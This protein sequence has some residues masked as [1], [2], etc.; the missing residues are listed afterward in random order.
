MEIRPLTEKDAATFWALRLEA[1]QDSPEAFGEA[2][3]DALA[4][5]LSEI[6]RRLGQDNNTFDNFI[7]GAFAAGK[8]VGIVGFQR[9]KWL[10]AKHR[11]S[12]WGMYCTPAERGKGIGRALMQE[13]IQRAK[14]LPGLDSITLSVVT[15]NPVARQLYLSLGFITYGVEPRVLKIGDRFLDMEMMLLDI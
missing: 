2:Y 11:A 12:I 8:L 1:L 13:A 14:V 6:E 5:P 15:T 7:L 4:I 10:K 9:D 3:E